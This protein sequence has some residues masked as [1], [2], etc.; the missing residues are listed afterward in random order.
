MTVIQNDITLAYTQSLEY[1]APQGWFNVTIDFN[2][3]G[4]GIVHLERSFD[5]VTWQALSTDHTGNIAEYSRSLND[6]F[7]EPESGV[8]YRLNCDV[9]ERGVI[10]Y[11]FGP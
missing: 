2:H 3:E 7:Y 1:A 11:R 4:R 10:H 9:L 8:K 5:G 6:S